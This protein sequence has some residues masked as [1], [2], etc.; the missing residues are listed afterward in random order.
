MMVSPT[1]SSTEQLRIGNVIL[2]LNALREHGAAAHT[3]ITER[4]GL[5]SA[6]VSAITA[7]LEGRGVIERVEQMAAVGRGR[8]RVLFAPKRD[9]AYLAII[10]ISS[11][12]VQFSLADY[13][14]T[15]I[16]RFNEARE[17]NPRGT[18]GFIAML[19]QGLDRLL[20]RSRIDDSRVLAISASSKGLVA[21]DRPELV[22]SP[23]FGSERIDFHAVFGDRPGIWVSLSNETLLVAQAISHRLDPRPP[24]LAALSLGHSIGLGI[25]ASN[26]DR[27]SVSAPNFGHMLHQPEGALC[28][29]G[30]KG[31]IEAY[32]GFYAILRTAFEVPADAIPA[33]FVPL[34]ELDKIAAN[35]RRGDRMAGFAFR[36]AGLALGNGLSRLMSL[37]DFM[38]IV[39]TGP[40]T[41]YYDLM[42]PGLE[43]GLAQSHVVAM[44]GMPAISIITDEQ[45]L[46]FS[47]H[48]SQ[49]LAAMDVGIVQSG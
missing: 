1:R 12:T 10:I 39:I 3:V 19:R 17:T 38:P 44:Q 43:E 26:G 41:R 28:R 6:T 49:A 31:C 35:A 13:R 2:V 24:S 16:D 34:S 11:D 5:S 47:G 23:V 42:K 48:L 25:V 30:A 33:K 45:N 14:G 9:F 40:G 29:C 21:A 46:A 27:E 32:S 4:T 7:E 18:A 20:E 22:W 36:Q 15:L 8:P 37:Y